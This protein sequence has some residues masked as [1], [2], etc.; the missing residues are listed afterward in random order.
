MAR[1]GLELVHGNCVKCGH[2]FPRLM[3]WCM[4][5]G[6]D[7]NVG[8]SGHSQQQSVYYFVSVQEPVTFACFT[9]TNSIQRRSKWE[10][11]IMK[12]Y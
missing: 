8:F 9:A 7:G 5:W 12:S 4:A 2:C 3:K 1:M 6:L 11:S 10:N